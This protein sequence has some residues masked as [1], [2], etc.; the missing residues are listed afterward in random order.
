MPAY[1]TFLKGEVVLQ[2]KSFR[3]LR[4]PEELASEVSC[5]P[6]DVVSL[7]EARRIIEECPRSF[8]KVIR[9]EASRDSIRDPHSKE[10]Y[11]A[12][13]ENLKNMVDQGHLARE[14]E[15][16]IYVYSQVTGEHTQTGLVACCHVDDYNSNVIRKHER[17]R[18]DKEDDR[19]KHMRAL[20]ANSGPVFL[21]CRD[22]Q[23][24]VASIEEAKDST[25]LYDFTAPDGVQHKLWKVEEPSEILALF[26]DIP[27]AY[28][29]DGHHRAAAAARNAELRQ[30]CGDEEYNWFMAVL[31]PAGQLRVLPY[32]RCITD[33]G[34]LS[35]EQFVEKVK[36]KFDLRNGSGP[37][38]D[39]GSGMKMYAGSE[40]YELIAKEDSAPKSDDPLSAL[41]ASVL[42]REI[43]EPVLN[44]QDPRTDDRLVFVGGAGSAAKMAEM[45]DSGKAAIAFSLHP[46]R[47]EQVMDVSDS[48]EIMPPKSTWF[49]PKLRSGLFVHTFD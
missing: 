25:L 6:Y 11:R 29:A 48:G 26:Q 30:G 12:S 35:R 33:L 40:W 9:P 15:P 36:E 42:Q 45:V 18:S 13:A 3:A 17:T 38:T 28:I 24:L 39:Q 20:N 32:N 41:D 49:E 8:M 37:E 34:E 46:V 5:P 27:A 10:A 19:A 7:E 23:R 14:N 16:C 31:F 1:L 21:T 2:I 43:L 22:D 47:I 44:I 4:P